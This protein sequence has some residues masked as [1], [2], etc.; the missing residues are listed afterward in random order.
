MS[1]GVGARDPVPGTASPGGLARLLGQSPLKLARLLV[2]RWMGTGAQFVLNIALGRS[3]GAEGL[4][5]F[6]LFQA[7]Y[8]WLAQVG[9]LGLPVHTLRVL[10]VL[11]G[12]PASRALADSVSMPAML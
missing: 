1:G 8:R 11:E 6:Y 4:G 9:A 3:L 10:S 7:W 2:S 5:V 12:G